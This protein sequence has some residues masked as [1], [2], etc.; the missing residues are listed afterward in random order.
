VRHPLDL[1]LAD[2][3]K[4]LREGSVS[5]VEL[6][7]EAI[8][9]HE[10]HGDRLRAYK[11]FD[12]EGA[13]RM[14][15]GADGMLRDLDAPPLCG[16]P[17]SVKDLYG[18]TG[19][20]TF[21]G[22]VR[23]LPEAWSREGWLVNRLRAQG[24]VLMGKTHTVELAFGAVG[25]NPH[26]GTPWNPW[27]PHVHRIPGGSSCGAGVSLW[28]GSALLA[29]GTDTGGSIRIPASMT[30]TAG[31]KITLG[32][33]PVDGV[34]PLSATLDTVGGL[35]RTVADAIH[36]FG[37]VDPSWGDPAAL[38]SSV[39]SD[40]TDSLRVGIP[41]CGIWS[42][43]QADIA[44]ALERALE[45]MARQGWR[46]V[47]L[48]GA[49][50]DEAGRLYAGGGIAGAECRAFLDRDLPGWLELLHP[51]V[52]ER[53]AGA[54]SL[55]SDAYAA[56]LDHR[57][58]LLAA[59]DRLFRGVDV[60]AL[61]TA[62]LTPPPTADLDDLNRYVEANAAALRPTCPVSMLDLCAVTLPVGVDGRGMPVGLQLVAPGGR[63]EQGLEAALAVEQVL[64]TSEL[65]P[66]PRGDGPR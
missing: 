58:R 13:R 37:A 23:R 22:T 21:A 41:R 46:R 39:S 56:A 14:A 40:R 29:L 55:T 42:D 3:A 52:G 16:I 17:V 59:S 20:P 35:S 61:P 7:E 18:V 44:D 63:D 26:W 5:A 31:H 66:P 33:W 38:R 51:S 54:P 34:V 24:A 4:A 2:V 32:R 10:E 27:D 15:A 28:E 6:A 60:L 48:D 43:C 64:G 45:A 65:R 8:R 49:L 30:G 50:L 57:R 47:E 62:V 1:P 19:L 53:L 25:I 11:L 36:F 9:R 12:P